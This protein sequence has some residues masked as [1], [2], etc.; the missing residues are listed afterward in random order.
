MH[1]LD[2][3]SLYLAFSQVLDGIFT[4]RFLH[5][6]FIRICSNIP[7]VSDNRWI[8]SYIK[9]IVKMAKNY[10][11]GSLL[12]LCQYAISLKSRSSREIQHALWARF[13]AMTPVN[14]FTLT[15][16][17]IFWLP[18]P[19]N[20]SNKNKSFSQCANDQFQ[21]KYSNPLICLIKV[22]LTWTETK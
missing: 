6:T 16:I 19:R 5:Y 18:L 10:A 15:I 12:L 7:Y 20:Y 2:M 9:N 11:I 14:V 21:K 8:W 4:C 1:T 17:E 3:F 13:K 22:L